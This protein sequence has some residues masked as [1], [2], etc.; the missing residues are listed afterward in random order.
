MDKKNTAQ[1]IWL[2]RYSRAGFCFINTG[3]SLKKIKT[4]WQEFQNRKPM[5]TEINQWLKWPTQ[6]YA[7]ICGL[8]SDLLVID[9]DTHKGGDPSPFLNRNFYTVRTPSGG[10][11]FYFKYNKE[12]SSTK[13][14]GQGIMYAIDIQTNG[15]LLF[16][17]P[18]HFTDRPP[19]E[20]IN[21]APIEA[22]PNDLIAMILET[23]TPVVTN[24]APY[25]PPFNPTSGRPGDVFNALMSWD[26]VLQPLGWTKIYSHNATSFWRRP[27]KKEGIS[28]STNF[29]GYDLFF[30]YTTHYPELEPKRGYTKF[31]L[32]AVLQ[33]NG[34]WSKAAKVIVADNYRI[35]NGLL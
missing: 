31:R 15:S 1:S 26:E 3:S 27:G 29:K 21:D 19:Y 11:H 10:Y 35:A 30:P 12:L 20:L 24:K 18:S 34:D 6:N 5:T 4:K 16:A 32:Y 7:L 22:M 28:A 8:I 9:V 2:T 23:M 14:N 33:H 25:T 17:P 13:H